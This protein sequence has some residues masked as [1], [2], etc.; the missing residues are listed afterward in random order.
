MGNRDSTSTLQMPSAPAV[1]MSFQCQGRPGEVVQP[2]PDKGG[3]SSSSTA[4]LSIASA[5]GAMRWGE[6]DTESAPSD[7]LWQS[8]P[9]GLMMPLKDMHSS[10]SVSRPGDPFPGTG[11]I[12]T[13]RSTQGGAP[14]QVLLEADES[15]IGT[16]PPS[17]LQS[18]LIEVAVKKM[19]ALESS[20]LESVILGF[21][22]W[23]L[24]A[25]TCIVRQG[26]A[27]TSGPGLSVLMDG[28]VDMFLA[29]GKGPPE[30]LCTYDR[31]GQCFGELAQL[32]TASSASVG[33]K[34]RTHWAT[35]ATRTATTLWVITRSAF[36]VAMK[37]PAVE[38]R[39]PDAIAAV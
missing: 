39:K 20:E 15:T 5:V 16:M 22:E 37:E 19:F 27:I 30:K 31:C 18:H 1:C 6:Y 8:G 34:R 32:Y 24:P 26:T 9:A 25:N 29:T 14:G 4:A 10:P 11:R 28:I 36:Q 23:R 21:R 2:L 7:A 13:S 33:A 35:I 17:R 38:P 12:S 3:S